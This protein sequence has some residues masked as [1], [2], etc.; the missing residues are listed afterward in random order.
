MSPHEEPLAISEAGGLCLPDA[1][2][3][4][5]GGLV[6]RMP[7]GGTIDF[8]PREWGAFVGNVV[9]RHFGEAGQGVN[10]HLEA[11]QVSLKKYGEDA[12]VFRVDVEVA[13]VPEA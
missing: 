8:K 6:A 4:Y 2:V 11:D 3:G 1:Y 12:E 7:N 10:S 5:E 13:E 9:P